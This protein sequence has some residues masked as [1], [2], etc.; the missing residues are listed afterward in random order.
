MSGEMLSS[1]IRAEGELRNVSLIIVCSNTESD[2]KRCLES[3]ANAFA[4]IP[5]NSGLLLQDAHQL[6][7]ISPRESFR[8]P[9]SIK[10]SGT[11]KDAPFIGY[12]ENISAS[13]LLLHSD[14]PLFEGDTIRCSFFLPTS[15]HISSAA[16]VVRILEKETEHDTNCYGV[17]FIDLSADCTAAIAEFIERERRRK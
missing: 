3:R 6:L 15:K 16:E 1:I 13:G 11:L 14:T 8:V 17:K 5:I 7:H 2:L 10:I 9:L 12:G 4:T